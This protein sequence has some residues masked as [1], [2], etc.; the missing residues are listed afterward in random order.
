MTDHFFT[1][2]LHHSTS[3]VEFRDRVV[4]EPAAILRIA[5]EWSSDQ[6]GKPVKIMYRGFLMTIVRAKKV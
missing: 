1:L 3:N 6:G 5:Q 4:Q 2:A